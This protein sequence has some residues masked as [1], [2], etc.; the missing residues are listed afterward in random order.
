MRAERPLP[1]ASESALQEPAEDGGLDAAPAELARLPQQLELLALEVHPRRACEERAIRVGRP[2]VHPFA[3]SITRL[4]QVGEE[5]PQVVATRASLVGEQAVEHPREE[6]RGQH[7][8]VLGEHRP[9]ALQDEVAQH[10]EVGGE[11]V[12]QQ[13]VDVGD[14]RD[15]LA[16]DRGLVVDED[17]LAAGQ[18]EQRVEVVGQLDEIEGDARLGVDGAWLPHLEAVEGTEDDVTG[19]RAGGRTGALPVAEHLLA[20]LGEAPDLARALHLDDAHARPEQV[21]EAALGA[22]L[23]AHTRLAAVGAVAGE[24]IVEERLR[25][26]ALRPRVAA[27]GGGEL[28]QPPADLLARDGHGG[29]RG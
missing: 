1:L 19:R 21:H 27:P 9:H 15:G 5:L 20:M 12:L 4:V 2:R 11:P 8:H 28:G 24:Q 10:V 16:R 22:L 18:E 3:G 17:R 13:G 14:E 7:L 29:L 26:A 6:V 23:E 25:L